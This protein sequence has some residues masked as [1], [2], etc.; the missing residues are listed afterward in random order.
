M[1]RILV[2]FA[3]G[4]TLTLGIDVAGAAELET[5]AAALAKD[6][7]Y[8]DPSAERALSAGDADD[9]RNRIETSGA[10]VF[11][12]V[13][14]AAV[15]PTEAEASR[16]SR[17]LAAATGLSGTY[18]VVVGNRFRASSTNLAD[19]DELATA[20]FQAKRDEGAAAVLADFVDR[21]A[22]SGVSRVPAPNDGATPSERRDGD[23]SFSDW[24]PLALLGAGGVGLFAWSRRR[25]RR[26]QRA[27]E[28]ELAADRQLLRA[29]LAVLAEDVIRLEPE[30]LT[31]P[32]ARDDYEAAVSRYRAAE[33]ALD[34]ADEPVDF[35]RVERVVIEAQYAMSRARAIVRGQRP[36]DPPEELRRPGRHDEP[37][38]E[39]DD[40]GRPQYVGFGSPFYGG[41]WFG[42]GGGLIS[43][44]LLGSMLGGWG[45]GWGGDHIEIHDHGGD[46]GWSDGAGGGDWG[47]GDFGGGDFGGGDFGGDVGGGDW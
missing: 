17:D 19:A 11:V 28:A 9:L 32:D 41:G 16:L 21:V 25:R 24:A 38:L 40:V 7:V 13:L 15:A 31:H 42:G 43:G 2:L 23:G 30:V 20:A 10:A 26:Q 37:P 27:T 12:A 29:E 35:V 14:P 4:L 3:I 8:V 36:P 46:G 47:G 18:A 34:Y 33:A 39:V 6:P 1:R 45:G 44:L 5:A 22:G